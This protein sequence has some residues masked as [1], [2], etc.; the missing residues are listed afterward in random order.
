MKACN[1][2]GHHHLPKIECYLE[3]EIVKRTSTKKII[4]FEVNEKNEGMNECVPLEIT[5]F[6]DKISSS[7]KILMACCAPPC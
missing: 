1:Y 6:F 7:G 5:I 4:M 3:C 2:W